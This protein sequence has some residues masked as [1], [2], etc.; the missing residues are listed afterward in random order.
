[1]LCPD[2]DPEVNTVVEAKPA[3]GRRKQAVAAATP[4]PVPAAATLSEYLLGYLMQGL[5]SRDKGVRARTAHVMVRIVSKTPA[6]RCGTVVHPHHRRHAHK[7]CC[8]DDLAQRLLERFCDRA[9]DKEAAVR[10][11]CAHALKLYQVRLVRVQRSCRCA[12]D[13]CHATRL[14]PSV[15]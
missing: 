7:V 2:E 3:K 9:N 8:S 6:I 14:L 4:A 11:Q 5:Q 13:T 10:V 1:M 12:T 15:G